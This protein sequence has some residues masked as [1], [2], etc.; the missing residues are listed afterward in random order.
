MYYIFFCSSVW[1]GSERIVPYQVYHMHLLKWEGVKTVWKSCFIC[2][3][4]GRDWTCF[5]KKKEDED[6]LEDC[7]FM[8][9]FM[10]DFIMRLSSKGL[11]QDCLSEWKRLSERRDC[12]VAAL[13]SY[14]AGRDWKVVNKILK[15]WTYEIE[16]EIVLLQWSGRNLPGKEWCWWRVANLLC[17]QS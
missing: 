14:P 11:Y 12:A 8:W 1:C 9:C 7:D 10:R 13:P 3:I 4:L 17:M 16:H 2:R 15:L 6:L 5:L